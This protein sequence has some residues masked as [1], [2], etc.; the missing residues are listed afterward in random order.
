MLKMIKKRM[1][2]MAS[3]G[4]KRINEF[5]MEYWVQ[6]KGDRAFP[7]ESEMD[8]S[9]MDDIWD[10]CFLVRIEDIEGAKYKYSYLGESLV[11]AYGDDIG[12]KEI[13]E[14]LIYP[15]SMSLIHKFD[16]VVNTKQPVNE[17][18]EFTNTKG[19]L[20]KFRSSMLPL[21]KDDAPDEVA[22]IIGGM[23]WKAY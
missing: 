12:N 20:I 18:S 19:M 11:E 3:G 7:L 6:K 17:D 21:G 10:S 2:N 5:L 1:K 14:K 13:C 15:T 4:S 8:P 16:E 23:K 9:E 22:F